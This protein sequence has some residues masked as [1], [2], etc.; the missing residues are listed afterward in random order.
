MQQTLQRKTKKMSKAKPK[1]HNAR[2]PASRTR[3]TEPQ[4][5][6]DPR[7][8]AS[9]ARQPR[10]PSSVARGRDADPTRPSGHQKRET[11][12]A[13]D[14]GH[15]PHTKYPRSKPGIDQPTRGPVQAG[16]PVPF[17][18][19][20]AAVPDSGVRRP[21]TK[22]PRSK[23]GANQPTRGTGP[24]GR[25]APFARGET[26]APDSGVR[27]PGTKPLRSKPGIDQPTRAANPAGRPAPFARG[28]TTVPDSGV[29]RPGG[30][31][32]PRSQSGANRP[33]RGLTRAEKTTLFSGDATVTPDE[34]AR[35]Y[36]RSKPHIGQPVRVERPVSFSR[37][38]EASVAE[39]ER[40]PSA[41]AAYSPFSGDAQRYRSGADVVQRAKRMQ[42]R[43]SNQKVEQQA[44]FLREKRVASHFMPEMRLQ[45]ALA[46]TGL[47]SR[48]E[49]EDMIAR[50]E[51]MVNGKVAELGCK[52]TPED[53]VRMG[54]RAIHI[55][56]PDRVPRVILYHKQ[57]GEIVTRDDPGGRV[58]VFARLPQTKSSK[59]VAVGRL[60]LNTSG[61]L[62][63]TTSGELANRMMHPSFE[64]ER[65]YAVRVLGELTQEQIK[66]ATRGIELE[67]GPAH[68]ERISDQNSEGA[69]RWYHV[70]LKEGRNREVR[71][72]FDHFGLQIS[73]LIRVR[74][75]SLVLPPRLKR[76]QFYELNEVEVSQVMK[77]AGLTLT[78]LKK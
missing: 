52:I 7:P 38:E 23:P 6:R 54:G 62:L 25:S 28:E 15:S 3:R 33:V 36:P 1:P 64:V 47:G 69:N 61:L 56:W 30:T 66:E 70:V 78:G 48:R 59:W 34:R 22:P 58:T 24:A 60:D 13:V 4:A 12:K 18:R 17:V 77:W 50:G 55:K 63:F 16:R 45:K 26:T 40:R 14:A 76:G 71:R 67:D 43:Q 10:A 31:K 9:G 42:Q 2:Q 73:R 11:G 68:F 19:E 35:N 20:E 65:E 51:V 32:P 75:G 44:R 5:P 27:R 49:M 8:A 41:R 46:Q 37:E 29:R 39:D 74:F 21:G 72:M 53:Q 57:E